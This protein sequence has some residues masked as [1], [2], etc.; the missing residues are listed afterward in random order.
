MNENKVGPSRRKFLLFGS[1]ISASLLALSFLKF[2][3]KKTD[4]KKVRFLTQDGTLVEIDAQK[5]K[6]NSS[7]KKISNKE[8]QQWIK[9]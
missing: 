9:R 8:L 7:G 5:A 3:F 4:N 1:I 6:Q 2:P